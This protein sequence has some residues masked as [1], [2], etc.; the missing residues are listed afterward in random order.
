MV[1]LVFVDMDDTFVTP[2]KVIT[3][4]NLRILDVAHERGVQFVP[5]TGRSVRGLPQQLVE[6]P[7][8][9]FAVCSGGALVYDLRAGGAGEKNGEVIH[10]QPIEKDVVRSLYDDVRDQRITFDLTA[11]DG[12]L[13]S[14]DR[15]PLYWEAALDDA[16]REMVL[17]QRTRFEGTTG[18]LIERMDQ[19]FRVNVLYVDD[20]GRRAVWDAVDARP[21]LCRASSIP[22]N[23]EITDVRATKGTALLWLCGHLGV[24]VADTVAFGDSGNDLSI[25]EV[26]GDGVAMGNASPEVKAAADHVAP[27]CGEAGVA[28][29]LE[30]ML[31][32]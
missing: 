28:R 25:I 14:S 18:E 24:A 29:Y 6:H 7:S 10:S 21:E 2:D 22:V 31:R 30:P 19:I 32:G 11:E 15:W 26:A 8:V 3:P 16:T 17:S 5:C 12:V 23:V 27:S 13:A 20:A 9:R 1:R 4:E